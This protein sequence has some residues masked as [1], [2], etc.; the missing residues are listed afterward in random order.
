MTPVQ[1]SQGEAFEEVTKIMFP[2]FASV[3]KAVERGQTVN[4]A[5]SLWK[6]AGVNCKAR[7]PSV[8]ACEQCC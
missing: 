3:Y 1:S 7:S 8:N 2:E 4:G 5:T 6:L